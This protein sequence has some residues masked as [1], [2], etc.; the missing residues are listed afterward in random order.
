[1]T[2]VFADTYYF[3]ALVN[4]KDQAHAKARVFSESH[5]EPI[6]TTAWVLTELADALSR[7]VHRRVFLT[8]LEQLRSFLYTAP[9]PH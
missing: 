1:M 9:A 3:L 4:A 2:A 8:L 7:A 5:E 6:V